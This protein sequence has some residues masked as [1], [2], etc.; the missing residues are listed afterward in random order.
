MG[1]MRFWDG[2]LGFNGRVLWV[3]PAAGFVLFSIF[4][5]LAARGGFEVGRY[6]GVCGFYQKYQR[7]CPGCGMSRAVIE[8]YKGNVGGAIYEQP[9]AVVFVVMG[10]IWAVAGLIAV[11]R[12]KR[13]GLA[14][15]IKL[16]YIVLLILTVLLAGWAWRWIIDL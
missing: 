8:L 3:L 10:F 12:G 7:P 2:K 1:K 9:A 4:A 11:V 14:E 6:A 13:L 15:R 16:K 5:F